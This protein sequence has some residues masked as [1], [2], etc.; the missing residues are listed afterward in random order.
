MRVIQPVTS[1]RCFG[2]AKMAANFKLNWSTSN[3]WK[4]SF[5]S[6]HAKKSRQ[7]FQVRFKLYYQAKISHAK[8]LFQWHFNNLSQPEVLIK[9]WD[10]FNKTFTVVIHKCNC[11]LRGYVQLQITLAR[12]LLNWPLND[13][14]KKLSLALLF[15]FFVCKSKTQRNVI[16]TPQRGNEISKGRVHYHILHNYSFK[17]TFTSSKLT[18]IFTFWHS[19]HLFLVTLKFRSFK[20]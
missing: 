6:L 8:I 5:R 3:S 18:L 4:S 1:Q 17:S 20:K 19:W 2:R 13:I 9:T 11:C 16:P 14:Q 7:C 15:I 12:I 10:L